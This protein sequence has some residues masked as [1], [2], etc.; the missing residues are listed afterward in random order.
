ML[1]VIVLKVTHELENA[2]SHTLFTTKFQE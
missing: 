2:A 1:L